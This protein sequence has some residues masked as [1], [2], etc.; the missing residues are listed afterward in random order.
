MRIIANKKG[1]QV[2]VVNYLDNGNAVFEIFGF[3][4]G[5]V[6]KGT[7]NVVVPKVFKTQEGEEKTAWKKIG[8]TIHTP[9]NKTLI[10]LYLFEQVFEIV[11]VKIDGLQPTQ[12]TQQPTQPTAT[13]T[14]TTAPT[15]LKA[16]NK[17]PF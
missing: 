6:F 9:D 1:K 12:P 2:G 7:T 16:E 13:P 17:L 11:E 4:T 3:A 8:E 15:E 5:W 14:A 10:E